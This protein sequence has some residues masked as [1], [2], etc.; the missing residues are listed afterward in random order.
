MASPEPHTLTVLATNPNA[1]LY[2]ASRMFIESVA[3][4][5]AR[6]WRVVVATA[7]RTGPLL[8]AV[9]DLGCE[10]RLPPT[11]VLR[12]TYLT[13]RGLLALVALTARS[14]PT[15]I[16]VLRE[17]R[18]DVL[19][20]NTITQPLWLLLGRIL[21]IPVVCHVH[22]G[23]ASAPRT[24]RTVLALPLLLAQRLILNS[25]FSM[26][27]LTG[28]LPRVA[29]R[30]EVVLN[31]VTGPPAVTPPRAAIEVPVRLLYVGRLSE[32]KGTGDAI[33]ALRLLRERGTSARLDILGAI[34]PGNE[35]VEVGLRRQVDDDRLADC[36]Q[37]LGFEPDIWPRLAEAD[38]LLVPSRTDEP[39]G[40]T[41]VEGILAA[42][43]VIATGIGGLGEATEGYDGALTVAPS[44]PS[45]IADAVERIVSGWSQF[46]T[47]VQ[48]DAHRAEQRHS[49][50][51]YQAAIVRILAS[52][53]GP[54]DA[55][56]RAE[57]ARRTE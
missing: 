30:C 26:S 48:A 21:R 45:E 8:D 13:P 54:G 52:P 46:R 12:K 5:R 39:F 53:T 35:A 11:P 10:V 19:Y 25:R 32:R 15:E 57:D 56:A 47:D 34:Y 41:A 24:V 9:R 4:L 23:E 44:A 42:R 1:D 22:E 29:D 27:V 6:G 7:D 28:V 50:A 49:P 16:R 51:E 38:I 17:V 40:N 20:V 2:G 36:V 3:G 14:I 37:F 31:G 43:P 33:E 55:P 18:P